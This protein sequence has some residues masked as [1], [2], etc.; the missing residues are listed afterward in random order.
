MGGCGANHLWV[1][2]DNGG[3][4]PIIVPRG[5]NP[6]IAAVPLGKSVAFPGRRAPLC[7]TSDQRGVRSAPGKRCNAG[8][9]Q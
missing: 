8:A 7:P 9:V 3:P 2:R 6:A 5:P 1:L 4:T